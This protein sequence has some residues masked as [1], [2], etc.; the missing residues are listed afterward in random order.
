[1]SSHPA[2]CRCV[3]H[4][5]DRAEKS[6][7]LLIALVLIGGFSGVE[8][9]VSLTSGSLALLAEAGHMVSDCGALGLSLLAAW[10]ARIPPSS[11]APFGYRRVEI[12]AA[13][14]NAV[15]LLAIA[16]WIG[17]ESV[18]RLRQGS[19][20]IVGLPMLITAVVGL[21]VNLI[22][23]SLL[24]DHSHHDLNL[25]GA[26][27]HMVADAISSVGVIIAAIAVWAFQWYWAD[28]AISLMVAV[29]IGVSAVPLLQQSLDVLLEKVPDHVNLD[30]V[31]AALEGFDAVLSVDTLRVWTIA[32]G[33][34]ALVGHLTV[35][36]ADGEARDRLLRE[37]QT[38]LDERFGLQDS[39]LQ[40]SAP[41]LPSPVNLSMPATLL[42]IAMGESQGSESKRS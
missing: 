10:I 4:V 12:L 31:Q 8:L 9:A 6:R 5:P 15:G 14:L 35:Q 33:H 13:L 2:E 19:T 23:A 26:F 37:I 11:R 22:N 29:L 36:P 17:W 28:G 34:D 40:M 1:M 3:Y 7:L 25:K 30:E 21:G 16:L 38:V 27:L 18:E 41:V 42:A 39:C 20:D 32:S 24:H